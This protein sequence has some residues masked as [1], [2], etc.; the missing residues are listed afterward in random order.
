MQ[1][2]QTQSPMSEFESL[3]ASVWAAALGLP[4]RRLC[5]NSNFVQLGGDSLAAL[6][7]GEFFS[8]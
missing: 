8:F 2:D 3:I 1:L 6:R 7:V 5:S 4:I